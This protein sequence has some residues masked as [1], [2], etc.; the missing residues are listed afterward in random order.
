MPPDAV[1][2]EMRDERTLIVPIGA[3]SVEVGQALVNLCEGYKLV[4]ATIKES[5]HQRDPYTTG[6]RMVFRRG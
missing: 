3:D 6:V 5:G 1:K 4:S 2:I